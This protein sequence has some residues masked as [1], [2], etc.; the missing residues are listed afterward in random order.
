MSTSEEPEDPAIAHWR[1]LVAHFLTTG[2]EKSE[3][4]QA[5][6][7]AKAYHVEYPVEDGILDGEPAPAPTTGRPNVF[8]EVQQKTLEKLEREHR[9][10]L[11]AFFVKK[12]I[13][14]EVA[15]HIV[16]DLILGKK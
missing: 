14:L 1:I 6:K 5:L 15:G 8:K 9:D 4:G 13:P 7:A 11:A 12:N 2:F 10:K 3:F 16:D